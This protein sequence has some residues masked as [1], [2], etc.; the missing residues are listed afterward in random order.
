MIIHQPADGLQWTG[1]FAYYIKTWDKTL[2]GL[3]PKSAGPY[4]SKNK[5]LILLY[6]F[7]YT[8]SGL[9]EKIAS[10]K[11]LYFNRLEFL[12]YD[13]ALFGIRPL[14][15]QGMEAA[16]PRQPQAGSV[17]DS[18]PRRGAFNTSCSIFLDVLLGIFRRLQFELL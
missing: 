3:M 18:P 1:I 4:V 2:R 12:A 17:H 16:W 11:S 7:H 6:I 13:P 10:R 9:A 15:A 5:Y 8:F 14:D